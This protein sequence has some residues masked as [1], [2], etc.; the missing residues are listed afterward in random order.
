[1]LSEFVAKLF[2]MRMQLKTNPD[3]EISRNEIQNV[4]LFS[5]QLDYSLE[6]PK[7]LVISNLVKD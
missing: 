3:S 6:N 4:A 7:I 1:M 2:I 5:R